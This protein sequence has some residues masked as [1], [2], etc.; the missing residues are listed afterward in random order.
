MGVMSVTSST[1]FNYPPEIIYDFVSNPSNWGRTY[2]GSSGL[3]PG[4]NLSLPLKV[5]DVWTEKVALPNN[6]YHPKWLLRHKLTS[7]TTISDP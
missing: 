4:Q 2:A 6:T 3:P 7:Y 5:G 1:I